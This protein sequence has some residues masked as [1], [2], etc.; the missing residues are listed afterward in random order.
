MYNFKLNKKYLKRTIQMET[1]STEWNS[2]FGS[3]FSI[4][5]CLVYSW[6]ICNPIMNS[7][8]VTKLKS[9]NIIIINNRYEHKTWCAHELKGEKDCNEIENAIFH[10]IFLHGCSIGWSPY[11]GKEAVN[12]GRLFLFTG[13]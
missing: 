2:T 8:I 10:L 6:V 13:G 9:V 4:C 11:Q 7:N 1:A 12:R 3:V 5:T